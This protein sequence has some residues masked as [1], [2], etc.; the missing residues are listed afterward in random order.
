M[1]RA[2]RIPYGL[3]KWIVRHLRH[4]EVAYV[5]PR[6]IISF[7]KAAREEG[8]YI[9][10]NTIRRDGRLLWRIMRVRDGHP[11]GHIGQR[12]PRRERATGRFLEGVS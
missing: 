12:M 9:V 2:P 10:S 11:S 1:T 8:V 5:R 6:Y 7:R 4:G 3:A